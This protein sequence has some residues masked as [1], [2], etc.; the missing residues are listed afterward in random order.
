MSTTAAAPPDPIAKTTSGVLPITAA[1]TTQ[2]Q[3][4]GSNKTQA[5]ST[6]ARSKVLIRR[7]PPGITQAEVETGLGEAW[8]AGKGKVDWISFRP[9]KASKECVFMIIEQRI[10]SG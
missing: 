5:K 10:E 4:N 3:T 7:L 2:H 9:G 1:T 6:T 8:Q